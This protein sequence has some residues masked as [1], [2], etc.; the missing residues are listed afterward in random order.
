[1]PISPTT[2]LP[3][4]SLTTMAT[5]LLVTA[6]LLLAEAI[7]ALV[8][9]VS[10]RHRVRSVFVPAVVVGLLTVVALAVLYVW[11]QVHG[12][13]QQLMGR[14]QNFQYYCIGAA[15]APPIVYSTWVR[16]V[17][18]LVAPLQ[19]E[20]LILSIVSAVVFLGALAVLIWWVRKPSRVPPTAVPT[21]AA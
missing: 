10:R 4:A 2:C 1:M 15:H 6:G 7:S 18:G 14:Y 8:L 5:V 19:R 21:N 16:Y 9:L 13:Y 17:H 3:P 11:T 12:T 20:T